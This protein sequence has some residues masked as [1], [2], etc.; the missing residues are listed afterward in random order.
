MEDDGLMSNI[1]IVNGL[2]ARVTPEKRAMFLRHMTKKVSDVL[3]HDKFTIHPV[4]DEE[5]EHVAGAFLTFTTVN[6]A[7]DAL[8]RLNRFPFTKTDILSTYRWCALKAASEPPEEYK[9]PE[10]EQDTDADFAHT[11]AEDSMARPQFFIKQGESFDVEWYWFN[12]TTLKAELYRKPRPLKTDSVGQW[13][14]MDRRQKRLDPGLVYGALTSVRPMPAW[15]TFGRIM[16]SQHMGGLKLWGGRKMHMLFE[17]TELDIKAF[18]ISP[19]EKYLVV[20]SPK[21]VSVW[22]IRLSKKIRVLGGLDLADSDKWPIARYNA[23]DELVAISHACLEPMGQGK[24]FLYRAETMRALQVESNSETPVHSLVI[25]GLKVAEW[26]PAVGNQMAI[27]VQGGSSEGWK[28][29][30]QNLVV[31]DD[32]VRAEVI[33]QRNFLQAQRLDL[34]WHPQGTHLVVKV[35]KTN[36]TEYSIFSVGVKSAAAYQLKVENGLTPGRFAWKPSG[37][38]FAVICEDRARTGKLGDTSE[39]RIYCIKKQLKLIGH[40][41]TS[42]THLFWAPRGSRL[43]A[44]NYDKSTLHFYGIND[45]GACVQLERVTSPVTDTAWDPTGRF[46]AAWVSALRNSGDNQFR[47]FDLNGRELMQKSVRQLSHFAWRPLAP[48]VL[49]A[50][51][52]KHIQDNLREYSQRYQNEVKE[53]KER[54]E[55]ELQS[56]E[57]EK[58]E[59]YKKRMKGIARHHADK[60]LARTRE[61]L[62]ASSRWSRLWARRMKS[63]PPEEMI[64][65]EVVTEQRIERRRPLN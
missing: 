65:H 24:L 3:G 15:S 41:P 9:P 62:I 37:P 25:P 50:A 46:Y 16:V 53:Q 44:T 8:A 42:A 61:E 57:R 22:N 30:I 55:A 10:M 64:L 1:I 23:E 18:Y 6:S 4:L 20:K 12:Y 51:E 21:E 36:S 14:E 35:T 48:P 49:T 54:E 45:S 56:K 39:I 60:G 13:T 40:Y 11:M 7:E 26:N 33:E 19:Q 43:V 38:H 28:I 32:V 34:L 31:K 2:P 5:T 59:Q 63:L 27:L 52:I 47:I 29:I 17:V 58:E